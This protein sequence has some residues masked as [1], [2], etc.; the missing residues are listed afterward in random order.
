METLEPRQQH[1]MVLLAGGQGVNEV[2]DALN[3]HRTTL[4]RWR[5]HPEFIAGW[6]QMVKQGKEKQ[7]QALLELQQQA[8]NVLRDCLSSQNE[9]LRYKAAITIVEKVEAI[10]EGPVYVQEIV[11]KQ[12]QEE[13]FCELT[14][15]K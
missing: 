1:A 9:L 7:I 2:C 3:I 13:K 10:P 11:H 6:N 5:K 15:L 12:Q 4:W 14:D 8:F